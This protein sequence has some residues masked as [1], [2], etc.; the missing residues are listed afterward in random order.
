VIG[1]VGGSGD[2]RRRAELGG[3]AGLEASKLIELGG[4]AL[5]PSNAGPTAKQP[6]GLPGSSS[7]LASELLEQVLERA[8]EHWMG[9]GIG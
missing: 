4:R 8:R 6:D 3:M 9:R 5:L 2:G 7:Q 1:C